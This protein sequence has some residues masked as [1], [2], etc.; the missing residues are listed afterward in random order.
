MLG[1]VKVQRHY[2][3][4]STTYSC[5]LRLQEALNLELG[6]ISSDRMV[7]HVRNGKG[8]RDRYVPLPKATLNVIT[9]ILGYPPQCFRNFSGDGT[10][11][12]S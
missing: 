5:G 12:R 2:A 7:I 3:F 8:A 9:P 6:D 11:R 1:F 4:L 10:R